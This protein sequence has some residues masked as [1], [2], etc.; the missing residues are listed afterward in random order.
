M[1]QR[2]EHF[3]C[4]V[5]LLRLGKD[6]GVVAVDLL[7]APKHRRGGTGAGRVL[8][9]DGERHLELFLLADPKVYCKVCLGEARAVRRVDETRCSGSTDRCVAQAPRPVSR[10][11]EHHRRCVGRCMSRRGRSGHGRGLPPALVE[12][13]LQPSLQGH[14]VR[15][16]LFRVRAHHRVRARPKPKTG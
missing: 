12:L 6:E 4:N 11:R 10:A 8:A 14:G 13:A 7:E 16:R 9:G 3:S 2:L 15:A 1:L 5:L